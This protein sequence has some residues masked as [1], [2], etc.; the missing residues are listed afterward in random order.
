LFSPR[1]DAQAYIV[2]EEQIKKLETILTEYKASNE[3]QKAELQELKTAAAALRTESTELNQQLT[4]SKES[5]AKEI[6]ST[7]ILKENWKAYETEKSK[8]IAAMQR[9][10]RE[11]NKKIS[12]IRGFL[13]ASSI[14]IMGLSI[15]LFCISWKNRIS[16]F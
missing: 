15:A 9:E 5:L 2:T 6:Q 3:R 13:V 14:I 8:E 11:L 1:L 16:R 7:E 4:K 10:N 12:F